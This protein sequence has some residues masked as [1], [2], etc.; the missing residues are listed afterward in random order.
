MTKDEP[1]NHIPVSI[2]G[3]AGRM[4]R[5]LVKAA[6]DENIPIA[7]AVES[8]G[9][10]AIGADSG[11]LAMSE[12]NGIPVTD[13]LRGTDPGVA[14]DFTFHSAVPGNLQAAIEAGASGYVLATT[15]LDAGELAALGEAS[16]KIP[17]VHASNMSLGVNLL[18]GLVKKAASILDESYDIEIVEMHHRHKK[19]APSGT[20]LSLAEAAAAGRNACLK[21]VC[22]Y[23]REGI[24]GER[25]LGEICIHALRGGEVVGDHTVIF[26][27][28]HERIEISHKAAS[29]ASFAKGALLAARWLP[30]K[31]PGIYSMADV[32]DLAQ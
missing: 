1:M 17:I 6:K 8:P 28:E 14:I 3:A 30:G 32:L 18:L 13:S 12:P 7:A 22:I 9:H 23:G 27:G 21:D 11:A 19:D 26:A 2:L 29:R 31:M 15:G 20:A 24:S 25:T 16:K 10:P 4:G 5:M